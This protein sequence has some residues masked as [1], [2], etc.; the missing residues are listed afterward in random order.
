MAE[1]SAQHT[2]LHLACDRGHEFVARLLTENGA[3]VNA[4]DIKV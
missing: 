3:D 2:P 1:E 4:C